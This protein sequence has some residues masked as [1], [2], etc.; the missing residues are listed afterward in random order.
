MAAGQVGHSGVV[1]QPVFARE[2]SAFEQEPAPIHY[3]VTM[4]PTVRVRTR[5][6]WI[7]RVSVKYMLSIK[8]YYIVELVHAF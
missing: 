2:I 5:S 6:S 8:H 3:Q 4:G 1:V 7:A